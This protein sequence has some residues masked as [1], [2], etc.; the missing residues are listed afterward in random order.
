MDN[1]RWRIQRGPDR[2]GS[3][4]LEARL[5][6]S[7]ALLE[8]RFDIPIPSHGRH[9]E[10]LKVLGQCNRATDPIDMSDIEGLDRIAASHRLAWETFLVTVA[11]I[12]DRRNPSTPFT[13]D[14][15][16]SLLGGPLVDE[17]RDGSP[18]D[19]QFELT[20]AA[21]FRLASCSVH[22]GEPDLRLRYGEELVGVAA[23]RVRSLNPDQVQ[24]H[25]RRAAQQIAATGTR[26]WIAINLDSR[27]AEVDFDQPEVDL[28]RDFEEEFDAVGAAL[29]R[30]EMKPHVLGFLLF[31]HVH[32]WRPPENEAT[33]PS[34]HS[35]APLRWLR[36]T[37]EPG[38]ME[39]FERFSGALADRMATRSKLLAS[40]EFTGPL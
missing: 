25:A 3:S 23:K 15:F 10:A 26:G 38:D 28:L 7:L 27:F 36:L 13:T 35:A 12:E 40:K 22:D 14:R 19:T 34:L 37:D 6:E 30:T 20:V 33:A 17:G 1:S 16:K 8:S 29:Q 21:H 2:V 24:K 39:L 18:R 4:L 32:T 5:T 11:A 31:G 9:R